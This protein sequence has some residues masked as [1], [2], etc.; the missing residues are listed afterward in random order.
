MSEMD[1]SGPVDRYLDQLFDRLTGTGGAGRRALAEA[2]DHLRTGVADA[3]AAGTTQYEAERRAVAQFGD[4]DG[5]A[6]RLRRAHGPHPLRVLLSSVW[7]LAGLA[8]AALSVSFLLTGADRVFETWL[9][10]TCKGCLDPGPDLRNLF[11]SGV[12]YAAAAAVV[13]VGRVVA[14]R[15]AALPPSAGQLPAI[16]AA[17]S[18]VAALACWLVFG[19]TGLLP[20]DDA[21]GGYG[22]G[23]LFSGAAFLTNG[24]AALAAVAWAIV[25]WRRGTGTAES[26][27]T[28]AAPLEA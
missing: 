4:A 2:E 5:F 21:I 24:A 23:L 9:H 7:L 12:G 11:L 28:A 17:L 27:R 8:L 25:R 6:R 1:S 18:A 19:P 26:A 10:P 20:I 15:R 14:R 13:L 3:V 16:T 22:P